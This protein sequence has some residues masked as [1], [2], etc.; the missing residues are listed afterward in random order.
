MSLNPTL[1]YNLTT[2][3][4][5]DGGTD[6]LGNTVDEVIKSGTFSLGATLTVHLSSY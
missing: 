6:S 3:T 5:K 2:Q 4:T 1:G